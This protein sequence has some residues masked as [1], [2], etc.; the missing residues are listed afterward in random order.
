MCSV[1]FEVTAAGYSLKTWTWGAL[2]YFQHELVHCTAH[3]M[4]EGRYRPPYFTRFHSHSACQPAFTT[5]NA[6]SLCRKPVTS[7][8][9]QP[10]ENCVCVDNSVRSQRSERNLFWWSTALHT[11]SFVSRYFGLCW[12]HSVWFQASPAKRMSIC[13]LLGCYAAYKG[14]AYLLEKIL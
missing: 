14:K 4:D 6:F 1:F 10:Y 13:A 8:A 11:S 3:S 5:R 9:L 12:S 2:R 7:S